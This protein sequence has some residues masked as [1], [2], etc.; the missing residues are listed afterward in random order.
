M[1]RYTEMKP[2]LFTENGQVLFLEIRDRVHKLLAASG[3]VRGQEA[4]KGS[5]GDTWLMLACIDRMV[6]LG[7]LFEIL[8]HEHTAEQHRVFCA[9]RSR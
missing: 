1:Y 3:A 2:K 4:I 8:Q 6:E 5:V 9:R 7:E